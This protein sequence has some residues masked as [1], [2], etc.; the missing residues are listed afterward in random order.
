MVRVRIGLGGRDGGCTGCGNQACRSRFVDEGGNR[1][2]RHEAYVPVEGNTYLCSTKQ[3][4]MVRHLVV[5]CIQLLNFAFDFSIVEGARRLSDMEGGTAGVRTKGSHLEGSANSSEEL[6]CIMDVRSL[7]QNL[8][9]EGSGSSRKKQR[10][11]ASFASTEVDSDD[12]VTNELK[13][14]CHKRRRDH[15]TTSGGVVVTVALPAPPID[16]IL[17]ELPAE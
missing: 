2:E 8:Q 10:V 7:M 12:E 11:L 9:G 13:E 1:Q 17:E 15:A 16:P 14:A 4:E 5:R 3:E 6:R